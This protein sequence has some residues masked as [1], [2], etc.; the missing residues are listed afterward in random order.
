MLSNSLIQKQ[1]LSVWFTVTLLIVL[2]EPGPAY[3]SPWKSAS[4][5]MITVDRGSTSAIILGT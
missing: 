1:L 5:I 2:V 4:Y 3:P